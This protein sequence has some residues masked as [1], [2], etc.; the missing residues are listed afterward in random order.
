MKKIVLVDASPRRGGNS[1]TIVDTLAADL[2]GENVVVFKMREKSWH[3][4]LAC[5]ACQHRDRPV[6]VQKDDLSALLAELDSCD[7]VVLASPIY[8]HQ[9][10]AQAVAFIDRFYPFFNLDRPKMSNT[11]KFGKKGALICSFWGGPLERYQKYAAETAQ[12]LSSVGADDVRS[13]VFG[14]IPER[15]DVAKNVDYMRQI[16]ELAQW[17]TE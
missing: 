9:L 5:A 1:E 17:L 14:G 2:R 8:Y 10:C 13:L 11:S 7:A 4:C 6:C 16:H 12:C 15:G 3:P